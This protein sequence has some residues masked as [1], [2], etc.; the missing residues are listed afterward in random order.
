MTDSLSFSTIADLSAASTAG[1]S[2]G[3][4][5]NVSDLKRGGS[6][7]FE[8][9][10]TAT[11]NTGTVF[12]ASG[13][14]RWLR[15]NPLPLNVQWFG[16]VGDGIA[17]DY[18]AFMAAHDVLLPKGGMIVVPKGY[19]RLSATINQHCAVIWQGEGNSAA[20]NDQTIGSFSTN[21]QGSVL[22]IDSGI[23]AFI[24][25]AHNTD[26]TGTAPDDTYPNGAG[27]GLRDLYIRSNGGGSSVDGIW[28]RATTLIENV[29]IRGFS[30]RGLRIE[31]SEP[32][33]N[34]VKGNANQWVLTNVSL[35]GNGS[36]GLHV[37]SNDTN[38]GIATRLDCTDNGGWGVLDESLIGNTYVACHQSYNVLGAIKTGDGAPNTVIGDYIET[39]A[40]VGANVDFGNATTAIGHLAGQSPSSSI[41]TRAFVM[42]A[43]LSV[44]A[45][46]RHLNRRKEPKVLGV[47]GSFQPNYGAIG[48]GSN[49]DVIGINNQADWQIQY[50]PTSQWWDFQYQGGGN[51]FTVMRFPTGSTLAN[52]RKF[53]A[54]FPNGH[55]LGGLF[56]GIGSA[57]PTTGAWLQGDVIENSAP[58]AGGNA[59][60][61]CTAAGSP[62]TWKSFGAI[63]A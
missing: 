18:P 23:Q 50:N 48:W 31:A 37:K 20:V 40:E 56:R 34:P 52:P 46:Y 32:P 15:I 5:A 16:A 28:M 29:T 55:F 10:S 53:V 41:D 44:G 27:S 13:G 54:D 60:W 24:I 1:L 9:G 36:H 3:Q 30:G 63:A 62:G 35:I 12:A 42:T 4:T 45:P 57:A 38:A 39:E 47:L 22:L 51:P 26:G 58:A 2:S 61:I 7:R 19:Y 33:S 6:F 8:S 59:G 21:A 43:G 25:N 17:D 49:N 11:T 14:G